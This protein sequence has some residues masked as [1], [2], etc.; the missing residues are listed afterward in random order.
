MLHIW[1][2]GV[3]VL[4]FG[5]LFMAAPIISNAQDEQNPFVKKAMEA[6]KKGNYDAAI[7][8][9]S[10]ALEG[11]PDDP[12]LL[13]GRGSA[14]E[15]KGDY[16]KAVEDFSR[17]IEARPS[18]VYAYFERGVQYEMLDRYEDAIKDLSKAIELK[19]DYA[20][21]YNELT[22][23]YA[24]CSKPEFRDAAKALA[25]GM[26]ACELTQWK[27]FEFIDTLAQAEASAGN[28]DDAVK[29]EEKA[30]TMAKSA[31]VDAD[32]F[33]KQLNHYKNHQPYSLSDRVGSV[34][35][36]KSGGSAG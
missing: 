33:E 12:K 2:N 25:V 13:C 8:Q 21:A 15:G 23:I 1:G 7:A 36:S 29:Y 11:S 34:A 27:N 35:G 32:H 31:K 18:F 20:V 14:Y 19:P 30:I 6:A 9:W 5:L 28:F 17:A 4:A 22:G 24:A 3:R 10:A 16:G 26:K